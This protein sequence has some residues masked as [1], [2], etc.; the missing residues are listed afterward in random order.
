MSFPTHFEAF[1]VY[2]PFRDARLDVPETVEVPLPD[3]GSLLDETAAG[4]GR[5]ATLTGP[6]VFNAEQ[7]LPT[8]YRLPYTV[9][10][11]T[12]NTAPS[13]AAEVRVI[14]QLDSDLDL[15]SFRLGDIKLGDITVH[16]PAG[17]GSFQGD[18]DF[19]SQLG[20]ILR[21]STGPDVAANSA[22]WLLQAIDPDTGEVVRDPNLG[23]LPPNNAEGAGAGFVSYSILPKKGLTSGTEITAEARVLLNNA[24]PEDTNRIVQQIDGAAPVRRSP[25]TPLLLVVPISALNGR[26]P[27]TEAGSGVQH[28]TIYVAEDEGDFTIWKSQTTDT[29]AIYVGRPGHAYEFLALATDVAGN[30]ERPPAGITAPDDG[31]SVNLGTLPDVGETQAPDLGPPAEPSPSHRPTRCSSQLKKPIPSDVDD[32]ST[33]RVRHGTQAVQGRGVRHG[34]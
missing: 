6:Q 20:F 1:N 29:S 25:R 2:V 33:V 7:W 5:L 23:L 18:F 9:R 15:F 19:T 34:H 8:D 4:F 24:P 30:Q 10:F 16:M 26:R 21:V 14:A 28:V 27:M 31:T 22:V 17:R 11:E 3:Y 13:T 32:N 12:A